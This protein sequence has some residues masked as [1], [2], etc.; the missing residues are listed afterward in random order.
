[1]TDSPKIYAIYAQFE[2]PCENRN[3]HTWTMCSKSEDSCESRYACKNLWRV[4]L[5]P[6]EQVELAHEKD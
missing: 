2:Y 5:V 3:S 6:Q 1:M 4:N